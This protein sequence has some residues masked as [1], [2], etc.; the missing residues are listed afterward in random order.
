M[1]FLNFLS[2]LGIVFALYITLKL[3]FLWRRL[4]FINIFFIIHF[5]SE[6]FLGMPMVYY[7]F[8]AGIKNIFNEVPS[9]GLAKE[10][11]LFLAE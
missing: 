3:L 2:L 5:S 9:K 10:V 11:K 4:N 8:H 7:H 1:I 6:V